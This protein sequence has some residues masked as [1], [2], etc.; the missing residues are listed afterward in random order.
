[1]SK[2]KIGGYEISDPEDSEPESD[3]PPLKKSKGYAP[4]TLT[5]SKFKHPST[6]NSSSH[7]RASSSH[8][9]T[10]SSRSQPAVTP[11]QKLAASSAIRTSFSTPRDTPNSVPTQAILPPDSG[12]IPSDGNCESRLIHGR[13]KVLLFCSLA[14]DERAPESPVFDARTKGKARAQG[15][16]CEWR[17]RYE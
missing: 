10:S 17:V 8:P 13:I 14:E 15:S 7:P 1:M 5:K 2:R 3:P 6:P 9:Q 12:V 4:A 16:L 11:G